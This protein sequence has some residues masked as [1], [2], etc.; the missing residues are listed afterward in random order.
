MA[1]S[2]TEAGHEDRLGAE[3]AGLDNL[4]GILPAK[5][6]RLSQAWSS[7]WPKVA[8]IGIAVAVWQIVV[9]THWKPSYV[10]PGPG[11]TL[12]RFWV[13]LTNGLL[14]RESAL[15][16]RQGAIGFLVGVAIGTLL[17]VVIN[18][19]RVVRSAVTPLVSGLQTMP[20][21]AWTPL[22]IALFGLRN[23]PILFVTIIGS[24]PAVTIGTIA[25][26]DAIPPPLLRVG[27]VLGTGGWTKYRHVILPAALPGY[28]TAL[29]QG[30]AFAWRSLMAAELIAATVG[31][32]TLGSQLQQFRDVGSNSDMEAIMITI[33]LIGLLLDALVF[34]RLER[35]VLQRR[36]L[37]GAAAH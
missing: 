13:L 33:L 4:E 36:G 27:R 16:L 21:A 34:S 29:K 35:V 8:A 22:A 1:A 5:P 9:W 2:S 28:V 30:W 18:Q 10:L 37:T 31:H 24:A 15:T 11:P 3:I 6:S 32:P 7:V 12:R 25:A 17:A 14:F 23:G 20:S 26:I 19:V